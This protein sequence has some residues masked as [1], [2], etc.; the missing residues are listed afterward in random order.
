MSREAIVREFNSEV[1]ASLAVAV[2]RANGIDAVT[3]PADLAVRTSLARR[4]A[5]IV[6]AEEVA[7]ATALLDSPARK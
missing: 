7:R 4:T 5:V 1:E 6:R 2:L 3:R